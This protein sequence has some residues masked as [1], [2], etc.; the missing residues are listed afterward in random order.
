MAYKYNPH[1]TAY[2]GLT[3]DTK[4]ASGMTPGTKLYEFNLTTHIV[5]TYITPDNGGTWEEQSTQD[6]SDILT[7]LDTL[8]TNTDDIETKLT[9]LD[10]NTDDIETKLTDVDN[11]T[12]QV[13]AKLDSIITNTNNTELSPLYTA[14]QM[15][16]TPIDNT[17]PLP[18]KQ[19]THDNLNGNM[20][21]QINNLDNSVSNPAY[22]NIQYSSTPVDDTNPLP[23]VSFKSTAVS[24]HTNA[25]V[26]ANGTDVVVSGYKTLTVEIYGTSTSRTVTFYG[27]GASGTLRSIMGV[28]LSD[29]STGIN[30]T[31]TGELWQFDVTGL[32]SVVMDL[33]AVAGGNVTVPGR[34]V[35]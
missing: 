35:A 23:V 25:T 24:F 16:S 11:N 1:D 20:N 26:A 31:G 18:I 15:A 27:K 22:V 17:N 33:T 12:D 9:E 5:T 2:Y 10:T 21:L 8:D 29:F 6:I 30:A 13:E 19:L 14:I 28:K 7:K 3:T 34:L 4:P 32:E